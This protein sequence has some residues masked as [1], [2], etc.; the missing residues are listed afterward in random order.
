MPDLTG[1]D[2]DANPVPGRLA[3]LRAVAPVKGKSAE[4]DG[5]AWAEYQRAAAALRDAEQVRDLWEL[6][7]RRQAPDA[8]ALTVNGRK[9]AVRVTQDVTGAS[10]R[11]DYYRRLPGN[12]KDTA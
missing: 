7:I 8:A 3:A 5:T 9:V 4:V 1:I 2:A 6:E 10:W 11:K 12:R